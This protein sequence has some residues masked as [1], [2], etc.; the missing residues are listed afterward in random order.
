[1]TTAKWMR[2]T[3]GDVSVMAHRGGAG[4]WREN[5]LEAFAGARS[6]GADGV[7]LD[8]RLTRDGSIVVHHDRD[9]PGGGRIDTM[10]RSQLPAWLPDLASAV[11]ACEGLLL[12]VEIKFDVPDHGERL[13]AGMCRSMVTGVA[14]VLARAKKVFVSSFW[15][16]ALVAFAE[17]DSRVPT[18]LLVHPADD[19]ARSVTTA[20]NLGCGALHP[21]YLAVTPA[22]VEQCHGAGLEVGTWT[23]NGHD[24]VNSVIAAGVDAVITDQVA[25]ALSAVGRPG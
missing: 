24:D 5:T 10:T 7:E 4:T 3:Q 9:L 6:L 14:E 16:D 21:Y 18:G 22:L 20:S 13:D 25:T 1:V 8:A 19:A 17:A 2:T 12:D 23:V 15:P 11:A